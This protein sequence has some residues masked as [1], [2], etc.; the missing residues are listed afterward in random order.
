MP[1]RVIQASQAS[2]E[3]CRIEV[4]EQ[5]CRTSGELEVGDH[6]REM[7][8]MYPFDCFQLHDDAAFDQQIQCERTID[9]GPWMVN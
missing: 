3:S 9:A 5:A 7:D 2:S 8:G 4:H 1:V 6:L